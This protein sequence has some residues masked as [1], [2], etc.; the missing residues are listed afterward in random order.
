M[1]NCEGHVKTLYEK[2]EAVTVKA[3]QANA[4]LNE[5]CA[6]INAKFATSEATEAAIGQLLARL[7]EVKNELQV[8]SH[9][10]EPER[11]D[12]WRRQGANPSEEEPQPVCIGTP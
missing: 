9:R 11:S 8:L 6:N 5:A 2:V 12:Q 3:D 7:D 10:S 1:V 4:N